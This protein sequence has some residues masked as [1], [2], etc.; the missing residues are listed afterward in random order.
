[1]LD[2]L[3][4]FWS[5]SALVSAGRHLPPNPSTYRHDAVNQYPSPVSALFPFVAFAFPF[6]SKKN[7]N[8][9]L[10]VLEIRRASDIPGVPIF[11]RSVVLNIT[12][13]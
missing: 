8:T 2:H 11:P 12:F 10:G 9:Q 1:M 13:Q 5:V 7:K 3:A 4:G 6:N